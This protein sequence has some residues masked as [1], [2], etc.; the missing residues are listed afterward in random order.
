MSRNPDL[1][2][3]IHTLHFLTLNKFIFLIN[4]PSIVTM[5][6]NIGAFS[7]RVV[8]NHRKYQNNKIEYTD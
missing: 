3:F 6:V 2:L 7:E 5:P 8:L 1:T 4:N